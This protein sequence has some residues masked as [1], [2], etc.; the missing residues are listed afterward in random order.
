MNIFSSCGNLNIKGHMRNVA[1]TAV[2]KNCSCSKPST[3]RHYHVERVGTS[4]KSTHIDHQ[5]IT[6]RIFKFEGHNHNIYMK[7]LFITHICATTRVLIVVDFSGV[8]H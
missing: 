6:L 8:K 2:N 7:K 1:C 4:L 3:R 5:I